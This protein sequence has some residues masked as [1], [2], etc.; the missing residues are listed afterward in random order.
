MSHD[1]PSE[2]PARSPQREAE[3]DAEASFSGEDRP[4]VQRVLRKLSDLSDTLEEI[5]GWIDTRA[6]SESHL[7]L[8]NDAHR[9]QILLTPENLDFFVAAERQAIVEHREALSLKARRV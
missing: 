6:E 7:I 9:S 4:I 2:G 3:G 8:P 1:D 5:E